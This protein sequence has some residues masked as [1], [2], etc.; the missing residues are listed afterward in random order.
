M[1]DTSGWRA[2]GEKASKQHEEMDGFPGSGYATRLGRTILAMCDQL[3][4]CGARVEELEQRAQE[5]ERV[6]ALVVDEIDPIEDCDCG[7]CELGRTAI[8]WLASVR[9]EAQDE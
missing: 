6:I 4:D 1:I 9:E 7:E 5:V 2:M 3:D 8:G